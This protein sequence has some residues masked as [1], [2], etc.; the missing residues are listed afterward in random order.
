MK[1]CHHHYLSHLYWG[2]RINE[3]NESSQ[4]QFKYRLFS[5]QP[6]GFDRTFSLDTLPQE[7]PAYGNTDFR[8]PAYQIKFLNGT[9]VTEFKYKKFRIYKGKR[10]LDGL[11][12]TY[13]EGEGEATSIDITLTDEQAGLTAVLTYS[14]FEQYNAITRSVRFINHGEEPVKILRAMSASVDFRESRFDLLNLYGAH[15]NEC[16]VSRKSLSPGSQLIESSRGASSHQ[17]NPFICLVQ[18]ETTEDYGEAYGISLVYSGNFLA[19]AEVDQF[20]TARLFIGINPF[21]FSWKLESQEVF[22]TPE[23]VLV[24]SY[25][26]LND[27][28][29]TLHEL[30]RFRLAR[31]RYRD[32]L[33]PILLNNW[34]ATYFKFN[35]DK[36]VRLAQE[37]K[38]LG[39]EL[40][41]LDDGWFGK[42]NNAKS[43]LGDWYVNNQ[44]L[45]DGLKGLAER[46]NQLGMDFGI[47][48]EPEMVSM[49]SDLYRNH[50]DWCIQVP[51]RPK[52]LGRDQL[53]LD[54]T[55]EDVCEYIIEAV[56]TILL[57]A[58]I[59]Y[60]KWDM[61]RHM[62]EIGSLT[63]PPDR[64]R[65]TG[66]R[67][68]LGLYYIL[69]VLTNRHPAVLFESCSGGGGRFDP[70]MLYYMPQVWTSDNTDAVS[71][72]KIQYGTSLVYPPVAMGAHVSAS[73]NH[74]V[75]RHTSLSI[76]GHVALSGN[77]GY[78]LD[79][80]KLSNV[81]KE[82]IKNQITLYKEIRPI[83]QFGTYYRLLSPFRGNQAA[84]Q[85]V[86]QDLSETVV[87]YFRI[88][89][90]P[91]E[92]F[93]I[94]RLKGLDAEKIYEDHHSSLFYGGDELMFAGRS[95]PEMKGD[96]V[97]MMWRFSERT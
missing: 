85:F 6:E 51:N 73:P 1:I 48:F 90:Q 25:R 39:I 75:H 29:G 70:G 37:G 24:Y 18:P 26:G 9:T 53:V 10:K 93:R 69:E 47:W 45:P 67:Y 72:L 15:A 94:L 87:M 64:Q 60:V 7:Y 96:F 3:S 16:N 84:W 59:K 80:T 56:S 92:P 27:L 66:H 76:R 12:A 61:N 62:T 11:P 77:L 65:E 43:S 63:L 4:L 19:Q 36:L 54:L 42:R 34:E 57:S 49:D 68:I 86:S 79:L 38:E 71:R 89:A 32:S 22:Q 8:S 31:G 41:V 55:R 78:E 95:I 20:E 28:S 82:Q 17:H 46:I 2:R 50:P 88:M 35:A 81:E 40:F 5:P 23:A 30:Y 13:V 33:R 97:S 44:K 83:I 52:S 74:Q 58:P 91:A 21:D 14:T